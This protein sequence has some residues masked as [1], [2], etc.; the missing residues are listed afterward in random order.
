LPSGGSVSRMSPTRRHCQFRNLRKNDN[1]HYHRPGESRHLSEDSESRTLAKI[2]LYVA[3]NR[4]C[5]L[6][7][8]CSR[9][10]SAMLAPPTNALSKVSGRLSSAAAMGLRERAPNAL[11]FDLARNPAELNCTLQG[12]DPCRGRHQ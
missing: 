1:D 11:P 8:S 7:Q 4:V 5:V 10:L 6:R 3:L 2:S 12:S 9:E